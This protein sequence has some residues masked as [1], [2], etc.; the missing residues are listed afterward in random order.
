M[1]KAGFGALGAAARAQGFD[2]LSERRQ[3]PKAVVETRPRPLAFR[4]PQARGDMRLTAGG[5]ALQTSVAA[6]GRIAGRL[7]W[8]LLAAALA[9]CGGGGEP[10][11]T[12]VYR[13]TGS[14]QCSGG[15]IPLATMQQQLVAGGVI[16]L[17][18]ACG[19]D[20]KAYVTLCG[21]PDGAI[22]IFDIPAE[23]IDRALSLS[24]ARLTDLP[25]AARVPCR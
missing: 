16:V 25:R 6:A 22:G 14:V 13:Y 1:D 12:A 19:I 7:P 10:A 17:D 21:A 8:L 11:T 2:E 4:A 5:E 18:A 9:A 24:F 3:D 23:Q 15:G 20:G